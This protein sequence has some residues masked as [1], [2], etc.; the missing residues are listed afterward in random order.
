MTI[1]LKLNDQ[2]T[3]DVHLPVEIW[4]HTDRYTATVSVKRPVVGARLWPDAHVPDWNSANDV[5]GSAP[6]ADKED[7][8]TAGG[9]VPPIAAPTRR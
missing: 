8:A 1:R 6:P 9:L 3:E 5:W 2:S 4:A 7:G